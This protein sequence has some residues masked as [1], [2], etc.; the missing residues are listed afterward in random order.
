MPSLLLRMLPNFMKRSRPRP[1]TEENSHVSAPEPPPLPPPP[2]PPPSVPN[3]RDDF[4]IKEDSDTDSLYDSDCSSP[5]TMI[6]N[7][8][9][10]R[11]KIL[12]KTVTAPG[13]VITTPTNPDTKSSSNTTVK[14][15]DEAGDPPKHHEIDYERGE[16]TNEGVFIV[17]SDVEI[18]S[19]KDENDCDQEVDDDESDLIDEADVEIPSIK[20]END[21]DQEVD[22][23]ESDLIDE[24]D[25]EIPPIKD[26]NDCDQEVDDDESDLIA[27]DT[28]DV[29]SHEGDPFQYIGHEPGLFIFRISKSLNPEQLNPSCFCSG[30]Y[31]TPTFYDGNAYIVIK[32]SGTLET[33]IVHSIHFWIGKK[34][35][36][37]LSGTAA[38]SPRC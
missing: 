10:L 5:A 3:D 34:A 1:Q 38:R 24:A 9:L 11:S 6:Q 32:S 7:P 26:E 25:V 30:A 20:D 33:S 35:G 36:P 17:E 14:D 19:I 21:C 8:L 13:D 22:D 2:I 31:I 16:D 37:Y 27:N 28:D 23:D 29:I 4:H 15:E 18:P 12:L